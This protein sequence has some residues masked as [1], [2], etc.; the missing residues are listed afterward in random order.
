MIAHVIC[1]EFRREAIR[2]R[3]WLRTSPR[4]LLLLLLYYYYY[5]ATIT[6]T[7]R[8]CCGRPIF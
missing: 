7:F 5:S 8:F 2:R 6:D 4:M 1:F 3:L